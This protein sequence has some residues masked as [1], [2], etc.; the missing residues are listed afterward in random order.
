ME[1]RNNFIFKNKKKVNIITIIRFFLLDF[2]HETTIPHI[3]PICRR[4]SEHENRQD[5]VDDYHHQIDYH[6]RGAKGVFL[7]RLPVGACHRREQGRICG[8]GNI[9][10][11]RNEECGMRN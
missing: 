8:N 7:P 10:R 2:Q 11:M 9:K 5:S 1:K 6:L 3:R 4:I